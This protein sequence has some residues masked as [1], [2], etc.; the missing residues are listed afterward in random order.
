MK[1]A[2]PA[3]AVNGQDERAAPAVDSPARF[4]WW[5]IKGRQP[6]VLPPLT[7]IK[8]RGKSHDRERVQRAYPAH[9]Q[10]LLQDCHTATPP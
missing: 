1:V 7:I 4:R 9:A 8:E 6:K 10:R 5:V 3:G 2:N